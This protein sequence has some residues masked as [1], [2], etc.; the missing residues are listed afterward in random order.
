MRTLDLDQLPG[1]HRAPNIQEAPDVYE[2]ENRAVDPDGHIE[3]AMQAIAP[4]DGRVV[5]DL[6]AGTGF[7]LA[8]FHDKAQHVIA[9]EPHGPSR[10]RAMARVAALRLE[11]V[12]VMTGS[13]EALLLPDASVDIVHARFAY[14]FAPDCEPGLAELARVI[15]PGGTAFIIDNDWQHGTF[16]SWLQRSAWG[17]TMDAAS[18]EAFWAAHGFTLTRIVSEWRFEQRADLEAVVRIEF[19]P[20]LAEQILVEH[21]GLRVEY[22]YNLYHRSY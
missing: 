10:L 7:H 1:V 18:I 12:S 2:L 6:G 5:L 11:R 17:A 4:W 14:F 13:A 22:Y 20:E 3:A 21:A 15:R 19:P 9:V 16:A 8:R